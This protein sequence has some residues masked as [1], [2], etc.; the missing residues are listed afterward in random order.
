MNRFRHRCYD[1]ELLDAPG[2]PFDAIA[3]NMQELDVINTRLGGHGITTRGVEI[4]VGR[5]RR[6]EP[7]RITEIGCGGGD[8]LRA[9]A[10]WARARGIAVQLSGIDWNA[11]CIHYAMERK[12][13]EAI[14]FTCSDYRA[15]RFEQ[16]PDIIFSSLFCHHFTDAEL[17]G[18]LQWMAQ[19]TRRG[20]FI[21][22]L[23]RHPLAYHSIKWLTK[24]F[25]R[26]ALVKNDAP[27]SVRRGFRKEEWIGLM[28]A[29][30]IS[31][32]RIHWKWAFRWLIT[33]TH[34]G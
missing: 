1:K 11:A 25:S 30:R 2:I 22:D 24:L 21:N 13:N 27:L 6:Q 14:N 32:Y 34:H 8:N 23:H 3:R 18:Q 12:G 16:A 19:H 31:T 4:L 29:A 20:F 26:S 17:V 28:E 33:A 5:E 15:A 7:W 9:I 10:R